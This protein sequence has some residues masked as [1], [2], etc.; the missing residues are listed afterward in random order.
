MQSQPLYTLGPFWSSELNKD[1][2]LNIFVSDKHFQIE[3]K[4]SNFEASPTLLAEY[5]RHLERLE[6]DYL[7]HS[8]E[9]FEDPL[10][11]LADWALGCFKPIFQKI[12]PLRI[13]RNYALH[14]CLFPNVL[15]YSLCADETRLLPVFLDRVGRER[16]LGT[17]LPE[18]Q[19]LD[20]YSFPT[21]RPDEIQVP[22]PDGSSALPAVPRKVYI[23]GQQLAFFK[24]VNTGD[25]NSTFRELRAY[26]KIKTFSQPVNTCKLYGIVQIPS[27]GRIVGLLLSYIESDNRTLLCAGKDPRYASMRQKWTDQITRTV[28]E[29]HAHG[30]VWGDAKP[31]NVLIDVQDDACLIDFGGGYTRGWVNKELANTTEGD[32]H[33]LRRISEWLSGHFPTRSSKSGNGPGKTD[34]RDIRR[35]GGEHISPDSPRST[36]FLYF[37]LSRFSSHRILSCKHASFVPSLLYTSPNPDIQT[38]M[39]QQLISRNVDPYHNDPSK[40]YLGYREQDY[41]KPWA[42]YFNPNVALISDEVEKGLICSPWASPLGANLHKSYCRI[43]I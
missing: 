2:Q 36:D 28:E 22:V 42:K 40:L 34:L 12:S 8:N 31:D 14:D 37:S 24:S 19:E 33:G 32:L 5:L 27:S 3:L 4:A 29:L 21:Y 11:G 15:H 41:K 23:K 30:V 20:Y 6:P 10:E 25:V 26:A 16:L 7:P 18:S 38:K 9:E 1:S 39:P 43:H 35:N 17:L 13:D